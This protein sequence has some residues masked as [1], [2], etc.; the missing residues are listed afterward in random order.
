MGGNQKYFNIMP[1]VTVLGKIITH[2][3]PSS[4][5]VA[6]RKDVMKVCAAAFGKD[7]C[8]RN[9]GGQSHFHGLLA[10]SRG[11]T[12]RGRKIRLR[13]KLAKAL[14][15]LFTTRPDLGFLFII[16]RL[17]TMLPRRSSSTLQTDAL[18]PNFSRKQVG[19]IPAMTMSHGLCSLAGTRMYTCMQHDD[20]ALKKTLE[21]WEYLLSLIPKS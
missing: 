7:I 18:T 13:N 10:L 6:G 2:G 16:R 1:D 3:Y 20:A 15:D 5:A 9:T 11:G 8:R 21:V 17:C 19:R 4:G 14:N 12:R